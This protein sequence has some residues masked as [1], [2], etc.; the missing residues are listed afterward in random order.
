MRTSGRRLPGFWL[1]PVLAILPLWAQIRGKDK[2][3]FF[4]GKEAAANEVLVKFRTTTFQSV[5]QAQTAEEIDESEW[6]GGTGLLRLH[7]SRKNVATLV[8]ELSA[9][10]DVEYAEPNYILHTTAIP[11]DPRFGELLGRQN[12]GQII[13]ASVRVPR[14]DIIATAACDIS[15]GSPAN[16]AAVLDTGIDYSHTSL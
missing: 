10:P 12:T 7:S 6:V 9:R 14:P 16:V 1:I 3:E 11:N 15:T 8:S 4:Q 13:H 5:L 2:T